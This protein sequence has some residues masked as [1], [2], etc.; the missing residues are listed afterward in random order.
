MAQGAHV[1]PV[2]FD[3]LPFPTP[4]RRKAAEERREKR[5]ERSAGGDR[6]FPRLRAV[7]RPV[8]RAFIHGALGEHDRSLFWYRHMPSFGDLFSGGWMQVRVPARFIF[9]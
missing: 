7:R 6:S 2:R 1:A 8:G 9:F 4:T 5:G 3:Q